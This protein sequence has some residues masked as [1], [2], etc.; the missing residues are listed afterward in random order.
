MQNARMSETIDE[1]RKP[2]GFAT[3][4]KERRSEIARAG[5]RAAQASGKAHRFTSDEARAAGRK[6]GH[7]VAS[8]VDHMREIGRE[9]GRAR[10]RA[11]A[12]T[13]ERAT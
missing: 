9:G 13:A 1:T 10:G 11:H 12:K 2:R 4:S 8:D 3:L 7:A 5:G 6:G